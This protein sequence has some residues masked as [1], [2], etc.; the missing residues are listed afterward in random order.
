MQPERKADLTYV[1]RGAAAAAPDITPEPG[2][3]T[4]GSLVL[5]NLALPVIG[6]DALQVSFTSTGQME[7][8]YTAWT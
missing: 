6:Q 8:V 1:Y 4:P 5:D 3:L 7:A 2:N